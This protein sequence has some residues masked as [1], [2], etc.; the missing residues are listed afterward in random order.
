MLIKLANPFVFGNYFGFL[1]PI[2]LG[3]PSA[4]VSSSPVPLSF[5]CAMESRLLTT[6][7]FVRRLALVMHCLFQ[8]AFVND[9]EFV[10][11]SPAPLSF[12]FAME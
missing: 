4:F 7:D 9:S 1:K 11:S 2:K 5:D 12:D 3:N 6:S 8:F 10:S